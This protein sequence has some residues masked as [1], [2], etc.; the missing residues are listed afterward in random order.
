[1]A[2][3]LFVLVEKFLICTRKTMERL[4]L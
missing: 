2:N 3:E 4:G 1:M